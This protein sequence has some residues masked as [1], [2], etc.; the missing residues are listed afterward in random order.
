MSLGLAYAV[1]PDI[2]TNGGDYVNITCKC[3]CDCP[4]GRSLY[5]RSVSSH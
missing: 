3:I 1:R 2:M 4:A 5:R